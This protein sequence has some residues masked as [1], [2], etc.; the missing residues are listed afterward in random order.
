MT[1]TNIPS[2]RAWS[3]LLALYPGTRGDLAIAMNLTRQGLR[4]LIN[5]KHRVVPWHLCAALATILRKG[6]IDGSP[7][8]QAE[9]LVRSW[10]ASFGAVDGARRP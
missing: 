6:T 4:N 2:T 3:E 9:E 8:P 1:D 7:P 5:G 10:R